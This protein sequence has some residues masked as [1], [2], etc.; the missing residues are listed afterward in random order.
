MLKRLVGMLRGEIEP[1]ATENAPFERRLIAVAALL[2][3]A[4]YVDQHTTDEERA[5]VRLQLRRHFALAEA[6]VERLLA[7]AEERF[8]EALDD[9]EF[10]EAVRVGF[11]AAERREILT[12][13]FEVSYAD[14]QLAD[15]ESRLVERLAE[16]LELEADAVEAARAASVARSGLMAGK[17]SEE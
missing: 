6:D 10:A 1:E 5:S 11:G 15:L 9:W 13:I 8:A 14:G 4:M 3:E 7:L 12:M 17:P 2:L 16:Q